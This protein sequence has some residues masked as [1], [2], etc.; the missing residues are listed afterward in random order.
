MSAPEEKDYI[1]TLW[2]WGR[3]RTE[4]YINCVTLRIADID[5]SL[6]FYVDGLGMKVFDRIDLPP[7]NAKLIMLGF[8]TGSYETGGLIELVRY[9]DQDDPYT[10]GTGFV[11]LSLGVPDV[12]AAV[13]RLEAIGAEITVPPTEYFGG[14]GPW[15]SH[16]ND[17]DG[18]GI[19]LIQTTESGS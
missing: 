17:P 4:P 10:P 2:C 5:A 1:E 6:R 12:K 7:R 13:A 18:Y 11:H 15:M 16:L 19:A 3:N 14:K 8:D 9:L